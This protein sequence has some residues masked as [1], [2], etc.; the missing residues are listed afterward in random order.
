MMEIYCIKKTEIVLNN[1]AEYFMVRPLIIHTLTG[2]RT[3]VINWDNGAFQFANTEQV[4]SISHYI[5]VSF[6][7]QLAQIV[8]ELKAYSSSLEDIELIQED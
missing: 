6:H 3:E 8:H 1:L 5:S 7:Q 4:P 2:C